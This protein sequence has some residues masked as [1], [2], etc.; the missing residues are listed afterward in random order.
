MKKTKRK[1]MYNNTDIA[2][3]LISTHAI[4]LISLV[5]T[6][7]ILIIL[8]GISINLSLGPNGIF[9]RLKEAKEQYA[10]AVAQEKLELVLLNANTEK[11]INKN[12]NKEDFLNNMLE[13]KG[14]IVNEELVIVDNYIFKIDRQN[15]KII[16]NIGETSIRISKEIKKYNGKNSNDKYEVDILL[17]IDATSTL[18]NV[19]IKKTDG[20]IYEMTTE[21]LISGKIITLELDEKYDIIVATTDGKTE[22]RRIQ[23][24]SGETIYTANELA[25]FRD[26]VNTGLSY[27]GK[28]IKLGNDLDLSS[29]C[30]NING[31]EISWEP[32]G[33]NPF[34]NEDEKYF[35]GTFDGNYHVINNLY[36]NIQDP[37]NSGFASIS[38]G[39]F[40]GNH[41][42]IQ[43]LVMEN[44]YIYYNSDITSSSTDWQFV[45]IITG[46]NSS[47]TIKNCGI[48]SGEIRGVFSAQS[49]NVD[50]FFIG[51]LV[52]CNG[53][54]I[55]S[56]YNK[57]MVYVESYNNSNKCLN[58][59]GISGDTEWGGQTSN[60]YN[61]GEII[62]GKN[63]TIRIFCGGILGD[64]S[65]NNSTLKNSYNIKNINLLEGTSI[66]HLGGIS[67][68]IYNTGKIQNSYC[69]DNFSVSYYNVNTK[70][71]DGIVDSQTLKDSVSILN[72]DEEIWINDIGIN[73]GYPILKW[74]IE[75]K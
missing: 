62:V 38:I 40:C 45:G 27:E 67:G 25:E 13:E 6:I 5:I 32:I 36:I 52:G 46:H 60:C 43:N 51:G 69:T 8:A 34:P 53:G 54:I 30:G 16:E 41:G 10:E 73:D 56:C 26:K 68:R 65:F 15:L 20:T 63:G 72:E 14:I 17:K 7:I 44:S 21:E 24:K 70:K 48:N 12:Y 33:L 29:V 2:S 42:T 22:I 23:E 35:A 1:I 28:I 39:L 11:Q 64:L 9:T 18:K 31:Q 4:T 66:S 37:N 3:F 58:I 71:T 19:S 49:I 55:N 74:Q 61:V 75:K 59:G 47:G 50:G 57:G